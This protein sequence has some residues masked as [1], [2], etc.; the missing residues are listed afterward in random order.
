MMNHR[1]PKK[2]EI[3]A[4]A[5]EN[6]PRVSL[7]K[8]S[9]HDSS[10]LC[11]TSTHSVSEDSFIQEPSAFELARCSIHL[12]KNRLCDDND[13]DDD[14][15]D[16]SHHTVEETSNSCDI[17]VHNKQDDRRRVRFNLL[18]KVIVPSKTCWTTLGEYYKVPGTRP[19]SARRKK[20]LEKI[21]QMKDPNHRPPPP[22]L[23][24][25]L[26]T[27]ETVYNF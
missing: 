25:H 17:V 12:A 16:S 21:R 8:P 9:T 6:N 26:F 11:T 1:D 14:T 19:P 3:M 18:V 2:V 27:L 10:S 22:P 20:K 5:L 13:D 23:S 7:D 4:N 15:A 24:P